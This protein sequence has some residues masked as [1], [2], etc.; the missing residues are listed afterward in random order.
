[1]FVKR[2]NGRCYPRN[3]TIRRRDNVGIVFD[4][5][6]AATVFFVELG[7]QLEGETTVEGPSVDQMVG[8]DAL[9]EQ[10]RYLR[11]VSASSSSAGLGGERF[12]TMALMQE[13]QPVR[14][15]GNCSI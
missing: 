6:A 9:A 10:L 8:L 5:L 1:M 14:H 15:G 2:D 3:M 7:L 13:N 11:S 12:A 4:D